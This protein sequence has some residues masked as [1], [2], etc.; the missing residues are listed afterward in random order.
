[1]NLISGNLSLNSHFQA[2]VRTEP[3]NNYRLRN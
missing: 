2:K 1:M 3:F